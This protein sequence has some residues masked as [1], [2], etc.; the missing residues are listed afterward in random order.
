LNHA[1]ELLVVSLRLEQIVIRKLSPLSFEFA[2]ELMPAAFKTGIVHN[3]S[4]IRDAPNSVHKGCHGQSPRYTS[5]NFLEQAAK[6]A[7]TGMV[8]QNG[9]YFVCFFPT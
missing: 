4:L 6:L 5:E 2:F 7:C 9:S 8:Q 1:Q 3:A